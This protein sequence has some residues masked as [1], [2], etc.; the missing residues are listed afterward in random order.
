MVLMQYQGKL[1]LWLFKKHLNLKNVRREWEIK[2]AGGH[3][4]FAIQFVLTVS[5][6]G[7]FQK[8]VY[9]FLN[10]SD[11]IAFIIFHVIHPIVG[12][13]YIATMIIF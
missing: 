7:K 3:D 12:C 10:F 11:Q 8:E 2:I 9:K 1:R 4:F 13:K 5:A 6:L